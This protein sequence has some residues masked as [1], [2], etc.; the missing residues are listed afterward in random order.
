MAAKKSSR[1]KAAAPKAAAAN[2]GGPAKKAASPSA[3]AG[4]RKQ[5]AKRTA[6]GRGVPPSPPA[7]EVLEPTGAEPDA[8]FV[9]TVLQTASSSLA[10]V[11][12]AADTVVVRIDE[13]IA[14][15]PALRD[16]VGEPVTVALPEGVQVA[17]GDVH[18]FAVNAWIFGSGLAVRAISVGDHGA[19]IS[20]SAAETA[21]ADDARVR[22][23]AAE[24]KSVVAGV[25]RQVVHVSAGAERPITEHDPLWND[26]TVEVH[27]R[28]GAASATGA[29][30]VRFASS[31]DV[32]WHT[33]PKF[34]VG[35][36]GVW[37]LGAPQPPTYGVA[38]MAAALPADHYVVVDPDDFRPDDEATHLITGT[39]E[40]DN[41]R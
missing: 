18:V 14:G 21:S 27:E 5:A 31:R 15:G 41:Q 38:A 33:A 39:G 9:G 2:K 30:T 11:E 4:S 6:A 8:T 28:T 20:A 22:R 3:S 13:V 1:A 10:E 17:D 23:R 16:H 35:D 12:P 32:R 19:I 7:D 34:T 36:R 25:V 24:A 26:A 29:I 40:G 37:L